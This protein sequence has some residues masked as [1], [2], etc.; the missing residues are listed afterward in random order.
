MKDFYVV[1]IKLYKFHGA[2]KNEYLVAKVRTPNGTRSTSPLSVA[3]ARSSITIRV[4]NATSP[5]T[6]SFRLACQP[7]P[8][9]HLARRRL[10]SSLC[11]VTNPTLFPTLSQTDGRCL[12]LHPKKELILQDI[13]HVLIFVYLG[14]LVESLFCK[15]NADDSHSPGSSGKHKGN[16]V[17]FRKL[18]FPSP[19]T[20]LELAAL[21]YT[22]LP[23]EPQPTPSCLHLYKLAVLANTLHETKSQCLLL[24]DNCY[25]YAST[26]KK[27]LQEMYRPMVVA[28]A[29]GSHGVGTAVS[30][31]EGEGKKGGAEAVHL[32]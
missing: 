4:R 24:F 29:T 18:S 7:I 14:A 10:Y 25:F 3:A 9:S 23:S 13:S 2:S 21:S 17:L 32:A 5:P 19:S 30:G 11:L 6:F 12:G 15:R 22:Y 27:M 20:L 8:L 31:R 26:I 1:E 28:E 16:R